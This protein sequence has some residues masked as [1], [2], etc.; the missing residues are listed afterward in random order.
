MHSLDQTDT[1]PSTV[2]INKSSRKSVAFTTAPPEHHHAQAQPL[3]NS[4]LKMATK[5]YEIFES[6]Q[7]TDEMLERAADLFNANYGT[8]G[9]LAETRM[10][11]FAK[12]GE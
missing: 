1:M 4:Q 11:P 10:G 9:Q 2:G 8:W 12:A 3:R 6:N 7:I 5:L